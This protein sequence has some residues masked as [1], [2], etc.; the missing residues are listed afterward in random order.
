MR[1]RNAAAV[2]A[3]AM[4]ALAALAG[5]ASAQDE[6][7]GQAPAAGGQGSSTP[8]P[9]PAS[10]TPAAA[11]PAP[12][13]DPSAPTDLG[14]L[15]VE[16]E[17]LP[18]AAKK[19]SADDQ[20]R[21]GARRFLRQEAKTRDTPL[22][23][24]AADPAADPFSDL[25][26]PLLAPPVT[27]VPNVVIDSLRI[28][29]FLLPI[30]QAAGVEYGVRWEILAAINEIET[31]YGRNLSVSSAGAVGWMQFM[32]AT[33][34]SYGVDANGDGRKDPYN[35]VDAIFA[36]ARYLRAAGA[37]TDLRKA[38]FAYNH[39]EWYVNDV[40]ARARSLAALPAD[41]VGA[42]TGLTM[43][44]FPVEG[45]AS[46]TGAYAASKRA[47]GDGA[48]VSITGTR[49]RTGV[50]I[51]AAD[52]APVIAV[53]DGRVV[54]MGSTE[55][56]G[57]FIQV[58]DVYGNTYTYGH[59]ASLSALHIVAK[60]RPEAE[61]KAAASHVGHTHDEDPAPTRA[62]TAGTRG[63]GGT[64]TASSPAAVE[65]AASAARKPVKERLFA[66]PQR[67]RSFA[68]GG[69]RQ[70]TE[71]PDRSAAQAV[72]ADALGQYLAKP[73]GL[74][75]NDV[76]L[77]P[78]RKGSRVISGTILGRAGRTSLRWKPQTHVRFEIRPSGASAPRIDPTPI[79][80]GWRLL[81]STKLFRARSASTGGGNAS[82]GQ[83]LLMGK[84][85][86]ERRVLANPDIDIY[87]CGRQDIR[88]G[89]IDRRVLAT[90]EF[91]A[92]SGMKPTV[93]SLRCG[94]G[95]LTAS[96]NVSHH[97]SGDALDIAAINGTPIVGHQG[98]GSITDL[99]VRKLL[100]LQGTMKPA[101]I[102]TLME[103]AGTDNTYAMGDHDDH[104]HVGF[105]PQLG[106]D[107]STGKATAAVLQPGQW[108]RLIGRLG[109]IENPAVPLKPSRYAVK[110]KLKVRAQR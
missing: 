17:K 61:A 42:L 77:M 96:G 81:D 84:E 5:P 75:R 9:G 38:I 105:Q 72:P 47:D 8:T 30:Y 37:D 14:S 53:Q 66:D 68:A 48:T 103:Y 98:E 22:A 70:I 94:H 74:R 13:P 28:P 2:S 12:A 67:P 85:A 54:A 80:D 27:G 86:L 24:T 82:I 63:S 1:R 43:G 64:N 21:E 109:A 93:T 7:Q 101:Q 55:R 58:R 79:L 110:V 31:D 73:Y 33:W 57:R 87:E 83:V 99:A 40:L 20:R 32:P 100:T 108:S 50:D 26:S 78:L 89:I 39:A 36:A 60:E 76:A 35:P 45:D 10:T 106:D 52:G 16:V 23:P 25:P 90:L 95:Y 46:Y 11:T 65:A 88:A 44:R 91:L 19:P 4:A 34:A 97:S 6:A 18:P 56:L 41:V 62:A 107:P 3:A 15:E 92:A 104:I 29:P 51:T 71:V 69:Q 102:I 59:L 49:G